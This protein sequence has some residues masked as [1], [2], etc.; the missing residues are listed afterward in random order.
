LCGCSGVSD[1]RRHAEREVTVTSSSTASDASASTPD[2]APSAPTVHLAVPANE[3]TRVHV[4][5]MPHGACTFPSGHTSAFANADGVIHFNITPTQEGTLTMPLVCQASGGTPLTYP[6]EVTATS[7]A[8][9]IKA[10][11]SAMSSLAASHPGTSRPPL[12]GDPMSYTSGELLERGYGRRPDPNKDSARY[13]KW[14]QRAQRP[15]TIVPTTSIESSDSNGPNANP[16]YNPGWSGAVDTDPNGGEFVDAW[17]Q[18]N[19]PQAF[20]VNTFQNHSTAS[21]WAGIGGTQGLGANTPLWQAGVAEWTDTVLWV[22]TSNYSAWWQLAGTTGQ[23]NVSLDV[24]NGNDFYAEAWIC[25]SSNSWLDTYTTNPNAY[26]CYYMENITKSESLFDHPYS[27][28]GHSWANAF[29][30][31]E[32]IQEWNDHQAWNYAQFNKFRFTD[33]QVCVIYQGVSCSIIGYQDPYNTTIY[34][35]GSSSHSQ[36]G[37]CLGDTA[38]NCNDDPSSGDWLWVWW[39]SHS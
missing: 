18:F 1:Q 29:N 28:A 15:G 32:V 38:G 36:G 23:N 19:V 30:T 24:N 6:L 3:S 9:A 27:T 31:G 13:A 7:D 10:S 37:A 35:I 17:A 26:L 22:Q 2:A 34:D 39:N 33:D 12:S 20:A 5:V 4:Q 16:H 8:A 11:Q 25:D 14:L 21:T